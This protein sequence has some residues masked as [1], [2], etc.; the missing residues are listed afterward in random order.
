MI[1]SFADRRTR[2]LFEVGLVR[3]LPEHLAARA[4]RKLDLLDQTSD[5]QELGTLPGNRF[6]ALRG[7]REGQFSIAV[8]EQWRICFRFANGD[9]FDVE[10]CDYH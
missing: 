6:H 3:G 4:K 10:F 5:V 1:V 9:A 2:L 7:D 8:N